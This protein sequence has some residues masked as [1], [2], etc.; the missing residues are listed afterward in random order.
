MGSSVGAEK[1]MARAER[2][3]R[4]RLHTRGRKTRRGGLR[5]RLGSRVRELKWRKGSARTTDS[6]VGG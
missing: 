4:A 1:G 5:W 6:S 3:E 2:R